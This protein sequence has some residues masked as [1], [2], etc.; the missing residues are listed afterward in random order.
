MTC[1]QG[2]YILSHTRSIL[3]RNSQFKDLPHRP[4]QSYFR[5][6]TSKSKTLYLISFETW[7]FVLFLVLQ[8]IVLL[9]YATG[10][11]LPDTKGWPD[12]FLEDCLA[13]SGGSEQ[14]GRN[15]QQQPTRM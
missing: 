4:D 12:T 1:L 13:G 2:A 15:Q 8:V 7:I 14:S 6:L 3:C 11:E 5:T 9:C 10:P